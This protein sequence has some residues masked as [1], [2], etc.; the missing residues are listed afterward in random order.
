[1]VKN[2][3][4]DEGRKLCAAVFET[5]VHRTGINHTFSHQQE[6]Q[7]GNIGLRFITLLLFDVILNWQVCQ[8]ARS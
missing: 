7:F 8:P 2:K 1:M 5:L 6:T 3:G 4:Y